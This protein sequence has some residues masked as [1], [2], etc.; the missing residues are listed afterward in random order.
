MKAVQEKN[1]GEEEYVRKAAG[2]RSW[3]EENLIIE[4]EVSNEEK[5]V[6]AEVQKSATEKV[7]EEEKVHLKGQKETTF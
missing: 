7:I 2:K 6:K 3:R 4:G 5:M 1:S